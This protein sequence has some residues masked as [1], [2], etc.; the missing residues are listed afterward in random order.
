M[1]TLRLD[2]LSKNYGKTV[3]I[4]DLSL[5]IADGEFFVLSLIHI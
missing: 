3:G 1:S 4:K 5:D 2:N